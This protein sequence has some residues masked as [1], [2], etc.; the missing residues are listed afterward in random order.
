VVRTSLEPL[1]L[2]IVAAGGRERGA[3]TRS[4]LAIDDALLN[5]LLEERIN[6]LCEKAG[7]SKRERAVLDLMV[8]GRS[9]KDVARVLRISVRTVKYHEANVQQKLGA[10]SRL[11]LMRLFL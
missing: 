1:V 4:V 10:D 8:L 9:Q 11:D 5:R 2:E 6:A 3:R 7:L